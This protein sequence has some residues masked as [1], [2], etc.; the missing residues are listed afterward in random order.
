MARW[1]GVSHPDWCD[2]DRCLVVLDDAGHRRAVDHQS[3]PIPCNP[4]GKEEFTLAVY[5]W[6]P[7]AFPGLVAVKVEAID[8]G[9]GVAYPL[10][11]ERPSSAVGR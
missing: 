8:E 4:T 2:M 3:R 5:L 10:H 9:C 7:G 6:E 1:N 11:S